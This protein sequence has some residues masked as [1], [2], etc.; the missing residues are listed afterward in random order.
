MN[1]EPENP[2]L[3]QNYSCIICDFHTSNKKDYGRH[4]STLKHRKRSESNLLEPKNPKITPLCSLVCS[5]CNKEY[6]S[7]SGLWNHEKKCSIREP[8]TLVN[9]L[10]KDSSSLIV[11]I[12]KQLQDQQKENKELMNKMIELS[13]EP[14][15]PTIVNNGT[16]NQHNNSNISLNVFLNEKCKDALTIQE[17]VENLHITLEDLENVANSGYVK[18][19]SDILLK[20][21]SQME[22][23]KRP[24]HCT[25][26]KREVI[27]LKEDDSW[28]KD[29]K[30]NT[31]L[32]NVIQLVENKNVKNIP[33]WFQQHPGVRVL[34]SPDYIMQE[35]I[36]RNAYGSEDDDKT[37]KL[38]EKIIK[39]IA[40]GTKVHL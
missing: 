29:D 4:M 10:Q 38:R 16:M 36:I 22:L 37:N 28:N 31:K 5:T 24:I 12:L 3:P 14:R 19:I 9:T 40:Q 27:Y 1:L 21:L 39:T 18:G 33:E 11:D 6:Q 15:E 2:K 13:R 32:K 8:E 26:V 7:K 35:K 34:D 30:E 23:T 17:F 20:S 25:D